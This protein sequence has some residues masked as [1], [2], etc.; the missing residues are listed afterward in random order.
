MLTY[1]LRSFMLRLLVA[2]D[3]VLHE[4]SNSAS[5]RYRVSSPILV[6]ITTQLLPTASGGCAD[7]TREVHLA[8]LPVQ[9]SVLAIGAGAY[10][11]FRRFPPQDGEISDHA[12]LRGC[13]P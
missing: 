12:R 8:R 10:W 4:R 3:R 7:T 1:H 2:L 13:T 9:D 5:L 6:V 11:L